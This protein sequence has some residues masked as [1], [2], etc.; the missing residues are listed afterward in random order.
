LHPAKVLAIFSAETGPGDGTYHPAGHYLVVHS[1][2]TPQ[3][4]DDHQPAALLL[5]RWKMEY[6]DNGRPKYR[7][8]PAGSVR[9]SIFVMD[10]YHD[11]PFVRETQ[12][13]DPFIYGAFER[14]DVWAKQFLYSTHF[15]ST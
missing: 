9:G 2:D 11:Q 4:G 12:R 15:V 3:P 13:H 1:C 7:V 14:A 5:K 8:I 6:R 10:P